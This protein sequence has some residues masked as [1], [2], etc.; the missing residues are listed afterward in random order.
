[1]KQRYLISEKQRYQFAGLFVLD[2]IDKQKEDFFV[3]LPADQK[4]LEPVF[5]WLLSQQYVDISSDHKYKIVPKGQ[6]ILSGFQK[7]FRCFLRDSDI[8]CAVDLEAGEFA[9]EFSGNFQDQE[10][11]EEFLEEERWEDL[12]VAVAE[13]QGQDITEIIFMDFVNEGYF[14][15]DE[16]GLWSHDRLL[17]GVWSEIED[18]G[19]NSLHTESLGYEDGGELI[20][21]TEVIEDIIRQG[22][23]L[24]QQ[25][26]TH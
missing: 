15:K 22:S 9:F 1:M 10:S 21:G 11:W 8:Y 20:S 14:G 4:I 26:Q 24:N 18:I 19:N 13:H 3:D 5:K 2:T 6:D 12:R 23:D 7:R 17:G 25:Y 16:H